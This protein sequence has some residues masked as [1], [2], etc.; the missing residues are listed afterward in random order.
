MDFVKIESNNIEFNANKKIHSS[1]KL[2][3]NKDL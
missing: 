3:K 2:N 1:I